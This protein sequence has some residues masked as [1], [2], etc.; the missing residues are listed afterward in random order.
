VLAVVSAVAAGQGAI[1]SGPGDGR[2]DGGEGS[3]TAAERQA[4]TQTTAAAGDAVRCWAYGA[5]V[6]L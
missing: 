4:C 1:G 3:R 5:V 6:V 2:R